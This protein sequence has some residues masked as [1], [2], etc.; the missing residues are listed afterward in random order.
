MR[1][2][3]NG[4]HEPGEEH[5]REREKERCHHGLRLWAREGG[6]E[7]AQAEDGKE[8]IMD[9][10]KTYNETEKIKR[11]ARKL[12]MFDFQEDQNVKKAEWKEYVEAKCKAKRKRN[13]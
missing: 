4:E 1:H 10:G 7:K 5:C 3:L 12:M 11:D 2:V 8:I 6:E 9:S 13:K